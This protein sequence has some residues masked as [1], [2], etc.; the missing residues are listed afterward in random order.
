MSLN[1]TILLF[2]GLMNVHFIFLV[3]PILNDIIESHE[4]SSVGT[5]NVGRQALNQTSSPL[6]G[7]S[8]RLID[9]EVSPMGEVFGWIM[10]L[11]GWLPSA[12]LARRNILAL[13]FSS[14]YFISYNLNYTREF[15]TEISF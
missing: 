1:I 4:Y 9:E 14:M 5:T 8:P 10:A 12:N 13:M 3:A 6:N 15:C 7:L 11:H 2:W